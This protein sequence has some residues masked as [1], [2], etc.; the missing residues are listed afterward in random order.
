MSIR[1]VLTLAPL[2]MSLI[3]GG[4]DFKSFYTKHDGIVISMAI[5]KYVYV[6]IK[7]HDPLFQERY[8]IS[9]SD[10]EHCNERSEIKNLI[11]RAA[12]TLLNIDEPLQISISSDLPSNSGLGSS[13]SFT[14]A[15]LLGLHAMRGEKISAAQLA[16]EAC[17]VEIGLL[18]SPIG[19]Q[20]QYASAFGGFNTFE[21]LK[22]ERVRIEP[23]KIKKNSLDNFLQ[24]SLLI[25]TG[26]IREANEILVDQEQRKIENE[27]SLIKIKEIAID[28]M[29]QALTHEL[30]PEV[31]GNLIKRSWE[32]K[33]NLSPLIY[34]ESVE[35][36]VK[37]IEL[38]KSLGYK[39][40]GAGG[41][42]FVFVLFKKIDNT[43]ATEF[44]QNQYFTPVVDFLGARVVSVN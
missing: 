14:V 34:D 24:N 28:F 8:R 21:F 16:E 3:G 13:S 1:S 26:K 40:L 23:I 18:K 22:D 30:N 15:L 11:V 44:R 35:K 20:D 4:T 41:G 17:E 19:K 10:V 12:L 37:K 29:N 36:L 32:L 38:T 42:G 7:K 6:H 43:I 5:Q 27:M 33:K 31:S 25:W 2:R 9:Y 39:L